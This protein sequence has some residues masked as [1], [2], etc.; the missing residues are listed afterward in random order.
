MSVASQSDKVVRSRWLVGI[1]VC[2]TAVALMSMVGPGASATAKPTATKI[3]SVIVTGLA[4]PGL[5]VE[6][7]GIA[8]VGGK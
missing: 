5:L 7:Q 3:K 8:V 4:V 6:V 1:I 2:A